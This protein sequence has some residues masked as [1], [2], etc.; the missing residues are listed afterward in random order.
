[1]NLKVG[2]LNV[3]GYAGSELA[4]IL[5]RHPDAEITSVTGR[6]RAGEKL[7]DVFPHLADL[8]LTVTEDLT[9]SADVGV[10]SPARHRQRRAPGRGSR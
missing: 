3:T 1:M 2:I 6:S 9:E 5:H 10:L 4:R 7:G 8:G